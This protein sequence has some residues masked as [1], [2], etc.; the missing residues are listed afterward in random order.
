MNSKI[1]TRHIWRKQI[2]EKQAAMT[3][4]S[5]DLAYAR[6]K[7]LLGE[8]R[9]TSIK[10][11][12]QVIQTAA[13]VT[14]R[15]LQ[16]RISEVITLA[17]AS[18][19]ED[20]YTFRAEFTQKRNNVECDLFFERSGELIKPLDDGGFG[21]SDVASLALRFSVWKD[22]G[23]RPVLFFDEAFRNL[24][25]KYRN[26]A[27]V[28][29]KM[30]SEKLGVQVIMISHIEEMQAAADKVF[31]VTCKNEQATVEEV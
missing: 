19:F 5:A 14:Q 16:H 29:L 1:V 22:S 13:E 24:S 28:M 4:I 25:K 18:I 15:Q 6:D 21:A 2:G 8:E 31:L 20:P 27:S 12:Q 10:E 30:L 26:A 17:L 9:L 3:V 23:T 11:A 7:V